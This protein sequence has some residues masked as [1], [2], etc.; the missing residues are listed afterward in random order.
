ME[1]SPQRRITLLSWITTF[2]TAH[3]QIQSVEICL[4]QITDQFSLFRNKSI[5]IGI[6][7]KEY[8]IEKKDV[9]LC[10]E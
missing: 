7:Y 10:L 2:Y 9:I 6:D 3:I 4:K 5:S 8:T 1:M